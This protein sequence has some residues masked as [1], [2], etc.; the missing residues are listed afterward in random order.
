MPNA[1]NSSRKART[2][3]NERAPAM[4]ARRLEADRGPSLLKLIRSL[5][6][7]ETRTMPS[8]MMMIGLLMMQGGPRIAGRRRL[9]LQLLR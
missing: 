5:I 2:I 1:W 9:I 6:G 4:T 8:S 7:P 3:R